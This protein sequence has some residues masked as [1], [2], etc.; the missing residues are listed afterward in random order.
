MNSHRSCAG[1]TKRFQYIFHTIQNY[2]VCDHV[3]KL[4]ALVIYHL[5]HP[6]DCLLRY[7]YVYGPSGPTYLPQPHSYSSVLSQL[8]HVI[9]KINDG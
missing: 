9:I 3:I 7:V 8:V 4:N 2:N 5:R 6:I 1:I